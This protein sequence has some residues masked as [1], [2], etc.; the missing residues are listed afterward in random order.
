VSRNE[1]VEGSLRGLVSTSS[2]TLSQ[3][4]PL[5][6]RPWVRSSLLHERALS[7][8]P[9]NSL[10]ISEA[11]RTSKGVDANAERESR[12][13]TNLVEQN[14]FQITAAPTTIKHGE[15]GRGCSRGPKGR[16][17]RARTVFVNNWQ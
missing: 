17:V 16:D 4:G 9:M 13:S 7:D 14:F 1:K 12:R 2:V 5:H 8:I 11:H 3:P 15:R 10:R 6:S